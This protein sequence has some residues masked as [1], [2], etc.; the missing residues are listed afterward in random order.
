MIV[1]KVRMKESYD[2]AKPL[3]GIK[4]LY[5]D[6][7]GWVS[8]EA[9]YDTVISGIVITS[10]NSNGP[11]LEAYIRDGEKVVRTTPNNESDDNLLS[12]PGGPNE[13]KSIWDRI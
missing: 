13:P 2:E 5:V 10:G 8:R 4:Q 7:S 3:S 1:T 9:V 12:L 6:A 11:K